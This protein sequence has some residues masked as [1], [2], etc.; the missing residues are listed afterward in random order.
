M[1][2]KIGQMGWRWWE[3]SS[4]LSDDRQ[5]TSYLLLQ[6]IY[7]KLLFFV[8]YNYIVNLWLTYDTVYMYMSFWYQEYKVDDRWL[9]FSRFVQIRFHVFYVINDTS[10]IRLLYP[11]QHQLHIIPFSTTHVCFKHVHHI[12]Y[13]NGNP[14]TAVPLKYV[15]PYI[16]NQHHVMWRVTSTRTWKSHRRILHHYNGVTKAQA[17][18]CFEPPATLVF[19]QHF[20]QGALLAIRQWQYSTL[21]WYL[22]YQNL[23]SWW[24]VWLIFILHKIS[25]VLWDAISES[26]HI[27]N[28]FTLG[29]WLEFVKVWCQVDETY[30]ELNRIHSKSYTIDINWDTNIMP[31]ILGNWLS[32]DF[33]SAY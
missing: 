32:I 29:C 10:V 9:Y 3:S 6:A 18:C 7:P 20:L 1:A 19:I 4:N 17:L 23:L 13:R 2:F 31:W 16:H 30:C 26:R 14:D 15:R 22:I 25:A 33:L 28:K 24:A 5:E 8:S 11:I 12:C 21:Y 27:F